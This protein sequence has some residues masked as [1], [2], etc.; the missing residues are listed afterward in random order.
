MAREYTAFA[1]DEYRERMGRARSALRRAGLDVETLAP[2]TEELWT[3]PD[4]VDWYVETVLS[5]M[6]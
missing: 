4:R 5:R 3:S 6:K 2:L 1:L